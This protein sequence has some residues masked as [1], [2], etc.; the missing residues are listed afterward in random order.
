MAKE[1]VIV[2]PDNRL[3]SFTNKNIASTYKSDFAAKTLIV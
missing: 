3:R 1:C 2:N